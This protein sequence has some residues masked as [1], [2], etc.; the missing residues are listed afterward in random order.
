MRREGRQITNDAEPGRDVDVVYEA[1]NDLRAHVEI[2]T[3]RDPDE[4]S[5][6]ELQSYREYT[7]AG[8]TWEC[9][10]EYFDTELQE[11][12]ELVEVVRVSGRM[13]AKP[14]E[15]CPVTLR[16]AGTN[17]GEFEYNP[18]SPDEDP[19]ERFIKRKLYAYDIREAL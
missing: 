10:R 9:G 17:F 6:R 14:A 12:F 16:F 1:S 8:R 2:L 19:T 3:D 13:S 11:L 4:M 7:V 18:H 15:E 5:F